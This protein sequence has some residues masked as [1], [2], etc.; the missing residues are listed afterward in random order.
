MVDLTCQ[1]TDEDAKARGFED[2]KEWYQ[3]STGGFLDRSKSDQQFEALP[4]DAVL[5]KLDLD[6]AALRQQV[7]NIEQDLA[8]FDDF[9]D[10]RRMLKYRTTL[11]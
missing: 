10:V 11:D 3:Y 5:Q 1:G 7:R 9:R 4:P 2:A 8:A 6:I